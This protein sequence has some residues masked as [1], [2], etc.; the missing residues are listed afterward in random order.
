MAAPKE[1][2][3]WKLRSKHGRDKI[4]ATPELMLEAA[5]EYFEW[6]DDNPLIS[7]DFKG[8]DAVEVEIPKMRAYTLHGLC[9]YL[10]VNTLYFNRFEEERRK[11]DT[12]IAKDFCKVIAHIREIIYNQ[13]FTGA[14]AGFLSHHIIARDLGLA[15]KT[16]NR[17]LNM[18]SHI[19]VQDEETQK[20]LD[21]LK[22]KFEEE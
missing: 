13:K 16:E 19:V 4:F 1:N 17:N 8:K 7:I 9:I 21:N 15:E 22:S 6:C 2:K 5:Y 11:E 12:E 3:F 20:E 18:E 10:G 14:A